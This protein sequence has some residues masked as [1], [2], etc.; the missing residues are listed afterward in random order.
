MTDSFPMIT[1]SG[2]AEQ[3]GATHGSSLKESIAATI[4]Y[5]ASRL[6]LPESDILSAGRAYRDHIYRFHPPY[7]EEI[8][9]LADAAGQPQEWIYVINARSE[10]L[11]QLME[12]S[13]LT[14]RDSCLLGQNWDFGKPLLDLAVLMYITLDNGHQILTLTEPG[15]IG[16]VGLN[17]CGL[18]VC[19][20]LLRLKRRCEGV[21][22]HI[23]LRAMLETTSFEDA[24]HLAVS[25]P[26]DRVGCI[27]VASDQNQEFCVEY[28]GSNCWFLSPPG[29]ISIHTNHFIGRRLNSESGIYE[30]SHERLRTLAR[31]TSILRQQNIST[32]QRLLSDRSNKTWP[33]H[34][35]WHTSP[36]PG[37]GEMGTIATIILD[38]AEGFM[39]IRKGNNPQD[40]FISYPV[41]LNDS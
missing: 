11:N 5:Y 2:S 9:A 7:C 13:T 31:L 32:M 39:H 41:E 35:P 38:L 34:T 21:P 12:C 25:A 16:K 10:L 6:R 14:F 36:I 27:T 1:V 22:I 15:M 30:S 17:S 37:L 28:A 26:G 20:N 8:D 4:A 23:V 24:K 40:T 19:L 33:V 18:G 29:R 3:R